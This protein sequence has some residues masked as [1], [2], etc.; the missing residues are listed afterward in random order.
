L[1]VRDMSKIKELKR[2]LSREFDIKDFGTVRRSL[3]WRL[4]DEK[5]GGCL[6]QVHQQGA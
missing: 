1:H 2:M 4:K 6:R 5:M 3:E